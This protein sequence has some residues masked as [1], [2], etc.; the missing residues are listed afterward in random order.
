MTATKTKKDYTGQVFGKLLAV[1]VD[2]T[3]TGRRGWLCLCECGGYK[4]VETCNMTKGYVRSCGCLSKEQAERMK[5]ER[6]RDLTG[7]T[8]G[9]LTVLAWV[10]TTERGQTWNTICV[11]GEEKEY[12]ANTLLHGKVTTCNTKKHQRVSECDYAFHM[13]LMRIY[14]ITIHDYYHMF[15]EQNGRCGIC[16]EKPDRTLCV[17]HNHDTGKIRALLCDACNQGLGHFSDDPK[18]M[19]NAL[20]YI[21]KFESES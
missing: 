20:N 4:T 5:K 11:C 16:Y 8:F 19:L 21:K 15:A 13:R 1:C 17:D 12:Y 18:K 9:D 7:K 14:G 10:R 6:R 3:D 2:Y